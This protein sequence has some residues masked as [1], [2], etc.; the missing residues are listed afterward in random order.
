M[1]SLI[2]GAIGLLFCLYSIVFR[3]RV[4]VAKYG[5][6]SLYWWLFAVTAGCSLLGYLVGIAIWLAVWGVRYA[7]LQASN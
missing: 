2:G 6:L 7:V 1:M 3:W 4:V 5:R